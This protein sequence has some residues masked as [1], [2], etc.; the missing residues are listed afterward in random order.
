MRHVVPPV[1][2]WTKRVSRTR[3]ALLASP[4]GDARGNAA[5]WRMEAA[6][7]VAVYYAYTAVRGVAD[8]SVA[9]AVAFGWNLQRFSE[10]AHIDVEM[11]LNRWLLG[12]PVL[13]V[14]SCYYYATAHFVVTPTVLF[15]MHR[16]HPE[17]YVQARWTL[18]CTTLV[19]L[20]GFFL[21]PTAP[22]RL[23]EGAGYVDTMAH[24]SAWGW[25]S[26]SASAAPAGLERLANQYAAFPSLHCA[27]ALL[28]GVLVSR[29]ARRPVARAL[30]M[31]YPLA[32][33]F[34]V[35]ATANHYLVDVV[36]G[37]AALGV[38]ALA[39]MVLVAD[40][41]APAASTRTALR[42]DSR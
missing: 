15:W 6:I 31:L 18:A 21:V 1:D 19:G 27:W 28:C 34:V 2:W 41:R 10:A 3:T 39:A 17:H 25:W 32:T 7:L 38:G 35:T 30:G 29:H 22:P 9:S 36:A 4:P 12:V 16:R 14:A 20:A 40:R 11:A 24:F 13:A 23:L 5:A 42:R 8:S 37:W 33:V 26:G